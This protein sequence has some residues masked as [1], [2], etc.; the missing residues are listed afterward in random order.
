MISVL[1]PLEA[2][3]SECSVPT[4]FSLEAM[5]SDS[6]VMETV[7]RR[8]GDSVVSLTKIVSGFLSAAGMAPRAWNDQFLPTSAK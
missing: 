7:Q 8:Y 3:P 6:V 5:A 4:G 2:L 1:T